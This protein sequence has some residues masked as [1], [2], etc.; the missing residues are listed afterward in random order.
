MTDD[1]A[2]RE[3]TRRATMQRHKIKTLLLACVGFMAMAA[4]STYAAD[5]PRRALPM[6]RAPVYVPFF[7]WT[8]FYAGINA[9]Y[10][11]GD[12]SWTNTTTGLG[13]GDFN[14]DGFL[15]GGTLGYNLQ[16]GSWVFGVEGDIGW[17]DIKGTT[18]TLCPLGCET[19]NTWLGTI[20]GRIGY[21]FDRFLPYFT[22]GGAFG[23]VQANP[24][25][26]PGASDIQFGWTVG[27]GIE[28]AFLSNWSAKLEYLYVDLGTLNC[29]ATECGVPTDVTFKANI[30]RGGLNYKF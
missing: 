15:I 3:R 23:E 6:P 24:A 30:V 13:T 5:M 12:S 29:T 9:G 14:V 25:V 22:A 11:F 16:T 10:G 17:S 4:A 2:A 1:H 18:T 26:L 20:R 21:A 7:S 27:A 8:G 19:R 28:Y